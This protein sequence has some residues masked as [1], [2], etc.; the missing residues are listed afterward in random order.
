M[1]PTSVI[2]PGKWQHYCCKRYTF[3]HTAEILK[4]QNYDCFCCG[5]N[6]IIAS[7]VRI[8]WKKN[9]LIKYHE[10]ERLTFCV[11]RNYFNYFR[12]FCT[13][14]LWWSMV[15]NWNWNKHIDMITKRAFSRVNILRKFKFILDRKTL[16]TIYITV[17]RPILEYANVRGVAEA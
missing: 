6:N 14:L 9:K 2:S 8:I 7:F 16:E 11:M 13:S 3:L 15:S 5:E 1:F 17:I 12:H 4:H 10:S